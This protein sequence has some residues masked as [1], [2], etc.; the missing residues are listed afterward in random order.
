MRVSENISFYSSQKP[1][2]MLRRIIQASTNKNNIVLDFFAGSGTSLSAAHKLNRKWIGIEIGKHFYEKYYTYNKTEKKYEYRLGLLGRM[3]NVIAGDQ[4]F[5]AIDKKRRSTMSKLIDYKGG[6]A[7]KY[8]ELES[9]EEALK[10]CEYILDEDKLI[11]YRKSRKLIKQLDKTDKAVKLNMSDYRENFDIFT[12]MSNLM[13]LKIKKL[14]LNN[15]IETCEFDNGDIVSINDLDLKK[16]P[17]L[18]SL[19]FW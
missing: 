18:K 6:G 5:Y 9:Y 14:Y 13:N 1:E 10:N 12:T 16:Y 17:K 15:D 3:K 7:F 2:N 8:Y 19:I 11:D 4:S